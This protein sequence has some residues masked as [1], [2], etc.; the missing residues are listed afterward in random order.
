[1]LRGGAAGDIRCYCTVAASASTAT[2]P[3]AK[4]GSASAARSS[5]G[6]G[7]AQE[8]GGR[9]ALHAYSSEKRGGGPFIIRFPELE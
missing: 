7:L 1:M 6:G 2:V 9:H 5:L 3:V 4:E 8:P